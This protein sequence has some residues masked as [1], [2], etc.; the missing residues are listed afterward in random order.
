MSVAGKLCAPFAMPPNAN[1][2]AADSAVR[3]N[4]PSDLCITDSFNKCIC[5]SPK[6]RAATLGRIATQR[7]LSVPAHRSASG[8]A[9]RPVSDDS[10][11]AVPAPSRGGFSEAKRSAADFLVRLVF[12][13]P[14][15]APAAE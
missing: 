8:N 3:C 9:R 15:K 10:R 12:R 5:G 1:A 14:F 6:K 7:I 2:A 11:V 13:V 4:I